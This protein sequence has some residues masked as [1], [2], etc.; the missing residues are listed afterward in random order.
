MMKCHII[1]Q[2][3][4][5]DVLK[6][7]LKFL[8]RSKGISRKELAQLCGVHINTV[9]KWEQRP[10]TIPVVKALKIS[11]VLKTD[12]NDIIFDDDTTKCRI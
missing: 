8:R 10:H 3:K 5:D 9:T 7:E 4:G 6:Y 11:E 2:M 12:I 1:L